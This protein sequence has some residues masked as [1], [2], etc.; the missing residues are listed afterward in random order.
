MANFAKL[1]EENIVTDIIAVNNNVL[2]DK[3]GVES[4]FLGINFLVKLLGEGTYVQTSFSGSF[5]KNFAQVG[6]TYDESRDAF[7]EDCIYDS[8]VLDK[9]TCKHKPPI[10]KPT[11]T[12]DGF[13]WVWDEDSLSWVELSTTN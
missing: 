13:I 6:G 4:E 2:L 8:W 3:N 11:E 1:N 5:R 10:E 12:R 9:E 7:I